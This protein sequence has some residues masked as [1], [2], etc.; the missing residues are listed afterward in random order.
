MV[1]PPV[2]LNLAAALLTVMCGACFAA[3]PP[4]IEEGRKHWAFQPLG[5]AALPIVKNGAW[6]RNEVDRFVLAKLEGA[7]LEP[8]PEADAATLIRRV[9]LDLIGLPPTPEEVT[10]FVKETED[11]KTQDSKHEASG[12]S[13]LLSSSL[14][15]SVSSYERLVDRLLDSPRYGERW[16]RHWLD[17]AR[18]ADTGGVHNDLDRPYAWK[19]RDYV[20]ASFND[21]KPYARFIAEQLAGDEVEGADEQSL[22]ATGFCRNGQSNDDN[23]GKTKEALEQYRVDQLDDV[24]STTGSVFLGLTIGCARC[25]DHKTDPLLQ[26]DYYGLMAV[27]NGAEKLGLGKGAKDVNDKD[28]KDAN[29]VM[30]LIETKPQVPTTHILLRG[31]AANKGEEV[32]PVAPVVLGAKSFAFQQPAAKTSLRRRALAGWLASP[33]NPLTWR[34]MANRLWQ[35]HFGAGIV[36]TPSN[37]GFTGAKPTHPELLDWLAS[38]LIENGGHLKPLHKLMVMSAT[39]RQSRAQPHALRYDSLQRM[40]AEVIRDT[41]LAASGKLNLEPGGP[42]FKPRIRADLLEASQRNKWPAIKQEGPEQWRRSV[43]IYVKRQL[44]MPALELFDAPT[45]TDSCALRTQSTVPTQALVLMNDEFVEDQAAFLAKRA[46][47]EAGADLRAAI[48]RMFML[49]L[50]RQPTEVRLEQ[51]L[52][53]VAERSLASGKTE[54][55][56]DLAHVIF[57]SSEFITVQ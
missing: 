48:R 1:R 54:A 52:A 53:F 24:I 23:M 38:S 15:S 19:Y 49:A 40:E 47:R 55:L 7:G 26:R 17:L 11:E 50:S 13:G 22:I 20:I 29:K 10:A 44:L 35:H 42:G 34:V 31:S 6:P 9:Y 37:F 30:A 43:Y 16:G 14:L 56:T 51:A 32:R 57:N 4:S 46:M 3:K 25:H 33:E 27:F 21:D 18:Y 28:I 12:Q 2:P 5:R 36:A 8:S 41:I 39:Y 45:T